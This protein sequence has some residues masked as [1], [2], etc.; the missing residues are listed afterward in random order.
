MP[1]KRRKLLELDFLLTFL[2][3]SHLED[4][5][6]R[7]KSTPKIS[8]YSTNSHIHQFLPPPCETTVGSQAQL[9]IHTWIWACYGFGKKIL[10]SLVLASKINYLGPC[11]RSEPGYTS[12]SGTLQHFYYLDMSILGL[13]QEKIGLLSSCLQEKLFRSLEE[14]IIFIFLTK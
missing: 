13:W 9:T 6:G 11:F 7:K 12:S 10:A 14:F 1:Q 8:S 2:Y 3:H 4:G 5:R